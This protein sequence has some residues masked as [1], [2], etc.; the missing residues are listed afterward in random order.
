MPRQGKFFPTL[1]VFKITLNGKS[2]SKWQ[3][4]TVGDRKTG[5]FKGLK[6]PLFRQSGRLE[7]NGAAMES[8]MT[9]VNK[10]LTL[11]GYRLIKFMNMQIIW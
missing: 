2:R 6:R 9:N 4:W 8:L 1:T 11:D 5:C 10:M 3:R 7:I